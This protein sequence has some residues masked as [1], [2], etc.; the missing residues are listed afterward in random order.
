MFVL[1]LDGLSK[2]WPS[3]CFVVVGG[4]VVVFVVVLFHRCIGFG[5]KCRNREGSHAVSDCEHLSCS[6][7]KLPVF[8]RCC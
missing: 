8:T 1:I 5:C 3:D 2:T 6:L 4:V 7:Q